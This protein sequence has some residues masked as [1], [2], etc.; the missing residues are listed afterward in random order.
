M[1]E[2]GIGILGAGNVGR[3]LIEILK[4]DGDAIAA[5]TGI[6]LRVAAV[7]DRSYKKKEIALHGIPSGDQPAVVLDHPDVSIVVELLGGLTPTEQFIREALSKGRSV[8]TANKALLASTAG[9]ELSKLASENNVN[10]GF[11]AAVAGAIPIIRSL[12]LHHLAG[13]VRSIHG[14][15]NGTCNFII[16]RMEDDGL[17][18]AEALKLAQ[19]K[20]FAEADPTFDV[21]G[22]DAAQKLRILAGIAFDAYFSESSI[23]VEGIEAIRPVD[24]K[25]AKRMGWVIRLLAVARRTADSILLRVHPAMIHANHILASVKEER[26]AIFLDS[27]STG[28]GLLVGQG[29]GSHPT[30]T[31]V[32]SDI[33]ELAG[34]TR[35]SPALFQK[36][37]TRISPE[38]AYR[39]YVRI[40]TQDQPGVLAE[41]ARVFAI[42]SISIASFHQEEGPE[43]VQLVILTHAAPEL[44]MADAVAQINRLPVVMLPSVMIR[45]E[46]F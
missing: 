9:P 43:P 12:R 44:A 6:R 26:N 45:V 18:Y 11:E 38:F 19:D 4:R 15:L 41:I 7:F 22:Q 8:V 46:D 23:R 24:L 10:L 37:G 13:Q 25:I 27:S 30:A 42:H 17:D 31:A 21:G 33:I 32:L 5:R 20:G 29:A 28:P 34:A 1:K 40:Q 2:V 39:Y 35:T 14:I 3:G 36:N 16:T